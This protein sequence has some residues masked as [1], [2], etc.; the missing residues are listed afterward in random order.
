MKNSVQHVKISVKKK[1]ERWKYV[2]TI[3]VEVVIWKKIEM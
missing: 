2:K 3:T 1:S